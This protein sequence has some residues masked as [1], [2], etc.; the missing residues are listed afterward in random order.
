MK[1]RKTIMLLVT[2]RCNLRCVYCYE[3]K[4]VHRQMT[5]AQAQQYIL[6]QVAK[7]DDSYDE[8]EVQFMGGEPLVVFPL[9]REISEWLWMQTFPVPLVQIFIPTNGTLLN[10][11]MKRWFSAHREEITLG[12]SFDGNRLMQNRNRSDSAAQVDVAYYA[13]TWPRQSVKMTLSPD[14]ISLLYDGVLFLYDIGFK[15]ITVDL[16][17]GKQVKWEQ[18]HLKLLSEQLSLLADYYVQHENVVPIS[19]LGIDVL[20]P[21]REQQRKKKCSCGENLVCVDCDGQE[22]AC[23]VFS[24]ITASRQQA[25]DSQ[26]IDFTKQEDFISEQCRECLLSSVCTKCYGMNFI[27]NGR[28]TQ[29]SAFT[30]QSFKIQYLI[31][32][33]LQLRLAKIRNDQ[34][35]Q[36][37]IEHIINQIM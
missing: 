18:Q 26:K 21:L 5:T 15:E 6:E 9:I 13:K 32:C 36:Q 24:P 17:M 8:F 28:I 10:E 31:A 23:H 29:Q 3:P 1:K 16:A 4:T 19:M 22:Y 33:D 2:Y 35:V 37:Q 20:Q 27:C 34:H 7:L 25:S 14:T 12:L 30:C 11:D